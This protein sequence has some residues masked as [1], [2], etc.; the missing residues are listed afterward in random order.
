MNI[1]PPNV[2]GYVAESAASTRTE[3]QARAQRAEE[4]EAEL[5]EIGERAFFDVARMRTDTERLLFLAKS[6]AFELNQKERLS[7]TG[8]DEL[9]LAECK[10]LCKGDELKAAFL[11][12]AAIG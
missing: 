8:F 5:S 3:A 2:S 7:K 1:Q 10:R 11:A 9:L 12:S 6:E 4:F